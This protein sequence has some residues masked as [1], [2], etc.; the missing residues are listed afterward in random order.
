[1]R[2]LGFRQN[3]VSPQCPRGA[4]Q[5]SFLAERKLRVR[6]ELL[7]VEINEV[8][9]PSIKRFNILESVP[10]NATAGRVAHTSGFH[11]KRRIRGIH[12]LGRYP[13]LPTSNAQKIGSD[14]AT[15]ESSELRSELGERPRPI[16]E[17]LPGLLAYLQRGTRNSLV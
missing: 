4:I 12:Q 13:V 8:E 17:A 2:A 7:L 6:K 11:P 15:R 5:T 3:C 10:P 14:H 1:M 16:P 9:V